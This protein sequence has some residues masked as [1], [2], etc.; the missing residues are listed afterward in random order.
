MAEQKTEQLVT[1]ADALD[2]ASEIVDRD[3]KRFAHTMTPIITTALSDL[4]D[5]LSSRTFADI[6]SSVG[7]KERLVS[8]EDI[9]QEQRD[10]LEV[11]P[12]PSFDDGTFPIMLLGKS[13]NHYSDPVTT[14]YLTNSGYIYTTRD[15]KQDTYCSK[16][17]WVPPIDGKPGYKK[18]HSQ[19]STPIT[20]E[21]YQYLLLFH[22]KG[23]KELYAE[24]T[25][26]RYPGD[27]S[28]VGQIIARLT[29]SIIDVNREFHPCLSDLALAHQR[30]EDAQKELEQVNARQAKL[31]A[32]EEELKKREEAVALLSKRINA[33]MALTDKRLAELKV[34]IDKATGE[35]EEACGHLESA[36]DPEG[37]QFGAVKLIAKEVR[38]I[39]GSMEK[40]PGS[41]YE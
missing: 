15:G 37:P 23:Q 1:T 14:Y 30:S 11:H 3:V 33:T 22:G 13:Q 35:M 4:W 19:M 17:V 9:P 7:N 39:L 38:K 27:G 31:N 26:Q 10:L 41:F 24:A 36:V 29:E 40:V 28:A 21:L 32:K 12:C 20:K 6:A 2:M 34:H 25:R 16:D 5:R 18:R 8:K